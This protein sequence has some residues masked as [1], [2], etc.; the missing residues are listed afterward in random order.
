MQVCA[1]AMRF[2]PLAARKTSQRLKLRPT[3]VGL[4]SHHDSCSSHAKHLSD[5]LAR[6]E[7]SIEAP[8][9]HR[10]EGSL[11]SVSST[12]NRSCQLERPKRRPAAQ[13]L[14]ERTDMPEVSAKSWML[15]ELKEGR[16]LYGKRNYKKR[17]MASLT[18]MMNLITVL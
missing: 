17:E 2:P 11:R 14:L 8:S 6:D 5:S 16:C 4:T 10:E 1:T 18:K 13:A 7:P 3:V 9:L 12:R 15:Y